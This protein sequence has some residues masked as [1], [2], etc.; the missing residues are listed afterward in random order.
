VPLM[1]GRTSMV[2]AHRLSTI[3]AADIIF[4]VDGGR[5]VESGSH[6]SLLARNG[7]YASLYWKQFRDDPAPQA[8]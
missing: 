6:E 7:I 5:I 4:V 8:V 1:E 2:I 3:L